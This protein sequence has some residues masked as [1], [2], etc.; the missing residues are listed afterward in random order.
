MRLTGKDAHRTGEDGVVNCYDFFCPA[1][2]K[3]RI[4]F[5]GK[6]IGW[7]SSYTCIYGSPRRW[8]YHPSLNAALEYCAKIYKGS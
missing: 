5:C 2:E 7:E 6:G 8:T 4:R 3:P 1:K